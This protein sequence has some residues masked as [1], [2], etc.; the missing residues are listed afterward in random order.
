MYV[1]IFVAYLEF[2]TL[3]LNTKIDGSFSRCCLVRFK[4][5][6]QNETAPYLTISFI[7]IEAFSF[8]LVSSPI[9]SNI[10]SERFWLDTCRPNKFH[11]LPSSIGPVW[12][13]NVGNSIRMGT[14]LHYLC[15]GILCTPCFRYAKIVTH[16][17]RDPSILVSELLMKERRKKECDEK[18]RPQ[19]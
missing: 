16:P 13:R 6:I 17:A 18:L 7:W 5:Y 12:R 8:V 9:Y 19:Y 11:T 4:R 10:V 15:V 3:S 1:V 2:R 14:Y